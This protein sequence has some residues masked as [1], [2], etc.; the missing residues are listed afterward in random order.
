M[1]VFAVL[2][3]TP[4]AAQHA[5]QR[6]RGAGFDAA[7]LHVVDRSVEAARELP[8]NT[9]IDGSALGST[10]ATGVELGALAA[11]P[12]LGPILAAKR[13]G[14]LANQ[15]DAD[16]DTAFADYGRLSEG[17]ERVLRA[18]TA[19]KAALLVEH[20]DRARLASALTA[21]AV[22]EDITP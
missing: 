1:A 14:H 17:A 20:A 5:R 6:L 19:G 15:T 11:I 16:F 18:V 7:T 3:N 12:I 4:E 2:F 8:G 10:W 13:L 22:I 21:D 9:D